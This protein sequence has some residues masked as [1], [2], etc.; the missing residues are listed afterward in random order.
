MGDQI[1]QE[2]VVSQKFNLIGYPVFYLA[3]LPPCD[4][5]QTICDPVNSSEQRG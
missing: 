1:F 5:R 2:L 3:I 4:L